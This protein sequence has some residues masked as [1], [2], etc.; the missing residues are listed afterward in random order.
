ML[1]NKRFD[2][3]RVQLFF[4]L[5]FVANRNFIFHRLFAL[6]AGMPIQMLID[7][8]VKKY[9]YHTTAQLI[10]AVRFPTQSSFLLVVSSN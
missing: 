6:C 1:S 2:L 4:Y 9:N 5:F 7:P 10:F 8:P 3:Q